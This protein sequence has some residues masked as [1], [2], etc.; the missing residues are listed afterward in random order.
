MKYLCALCHAIGGC[1]DAPR[2]VHSPEV[3]VGPCGWC[4][5]VSPCV[6]CFAY[7]FR[8]RER[9]DGRGSAED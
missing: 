9:S 1:W 2:L 5:E 7:D 3:S 4:G 8:S 6:A